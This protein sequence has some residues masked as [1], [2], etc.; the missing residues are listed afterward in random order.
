[1]MF[2]LMYYY[3]MLDKETRYLAGLLLVLENLIIKTKFFS[4]EERIKYYMIIGYIKND[5]D[6]TFDDA[7]EDLNELIEYHVDKFEN[8]NNIIDSIKE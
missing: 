2:F 3:K 7:I 6:Y 8:I 5:P 1:M 4:E